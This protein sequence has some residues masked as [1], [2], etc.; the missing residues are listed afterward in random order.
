MPRLSGPPALPLSLF[1]ALLDAYPVL[2]FSLWL[3]RGP[4]RW[5]FLQNVGYL[6]EGGKDS[7]QGLEEVNNTNYLFLASPWVG[8]GHLIQ[9]GLSEVALLLVSGEG[10]NSK[11]QVL[12]V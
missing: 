3:L 6:R 12:E 5:R 2:G 10:R 9:V 8:W 4:G 11:E 7:W 1:W